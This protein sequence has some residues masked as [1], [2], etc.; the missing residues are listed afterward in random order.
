MKNSAQTEWIR[1]LEYWVMGII[2]IVLF[3]LPVLFTRIDGDISWRHVLKIW[4]DQSLL[5]PLFA[6]NH[7]LFVPRLLLNQRAKYY[8]VA[9]FT[10]IAVCTISYYYYDMAPNWKAQIRMVNDERKPNPI[11]PYAHL[12][13]Y[14]LLIVAVDSGLLFS[15]KWHETEE[16]RMILEKQNAEIQLDIL[17]N[18][19]SP[20]FFMNTLNNIYALIDHDTPKAKQAVMKLSKMMRYMLYE[21]EHGKVK[22]S[23]EFEFVKS[24][25]DLM[26][27]RFANDMTIQLMLPKT[28]NDILIPPMLFVSYIENAFKHGA[29]YEQ[30][31]MIKIIFEISENQ[32][33]FNCYNSMN[34][35]VVSAEKG[36]LGMTNSENRL[37]LLF[38][39]RYR[40]M[41]DSS[42]KIFNV[43]LE[44]P[45]A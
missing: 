15:R 39:D 13:M 22:L 1:N 31:G 2:F 10:T 27:L 44:I 11:P 30:K 9:V 34:K 43:E 41:V 32:L 6:L 14:S 12:L 20:H 23:K 21:S 25:I 4:T 37:K 35:Q 19:I 7:C 38:G 26:K 18:Q 28:Y 40:L 3:L 5:L 17:R 36:G 8:F 24:Y 33:Y 42:Q 45:L 29:S 16:A